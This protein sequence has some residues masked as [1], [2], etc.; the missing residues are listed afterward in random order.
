MIML[1]VKIGDIAMDNCAR[2]HTLI[3]LKLYWQPMQLEAN[4]GLRLGVPEHVFK[5]RFLWCV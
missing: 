3:G 4:Y 1:S 5:V 2:C